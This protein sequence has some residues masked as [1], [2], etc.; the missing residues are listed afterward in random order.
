MIRS[1]AMY[2]SADSFIGEPHG[3]IKMIN[4]GQVP[5]TPFYPGSKLISSVLIRPFLEDEELQVYA[6]INPCTN[7]EEDV[8][9]A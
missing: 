7:Q 3:L 4:G 9:F 1:I 2:V 5:G 8:R 6:G